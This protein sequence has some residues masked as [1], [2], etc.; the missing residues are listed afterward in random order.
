V[1]KGEI[2][3]H[4]HG[5]ERREQPIVWVFQETW[6]CLHC[7]FTEFTVPTVELRRLAENAAERSLDQPDNLAEKEISR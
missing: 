6:V 3:V 4:F 1:F 5:L 2:A 7:G